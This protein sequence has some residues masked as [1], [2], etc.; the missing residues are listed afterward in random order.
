MAFRSVCAA[1]APSLSNLAEWWL[2]LGIKLEQIQP[3]KPQQNGP[4]ER[5][6]RVLK[7][8]TKRPPAANCHQQQVRPDPLP[9]RVQ[10]TYRHPLVYRSGSTSHC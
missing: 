5:M 6:H 1:P 2:N 8:E 7:A 3:G 10:P 4:R 9:R